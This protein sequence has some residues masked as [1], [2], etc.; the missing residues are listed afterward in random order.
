MNAKLLS[1]SLKNIIT[2]GKIKYGFKQTVKSIENKQSKFVICS[3][4]ISDLQFTQ[5]N[6]ICTQFSIPFFQI[7]DNSLL[8]GKLI[9]KSFRI[10][11]FSIINANDA[12][13]EQLKN[14]F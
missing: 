5:L 4:S 9:Q 1:K 11:A 3:S 7:H 10:S 2:N 12:D 8:T 6:D 14:T 13:I